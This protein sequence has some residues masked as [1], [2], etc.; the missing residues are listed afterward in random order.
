MTDRFSE[1]S[2]RAGNAVW[3]PSHTVTD[4]FRMISEDTY[5]SSLVKISMKYLLVEVL[6]PKIRNNAEAY[7]GIHKKTS[8]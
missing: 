3:R 1:T 8:L 5:N 4:G 7:R 6:Y 2:H